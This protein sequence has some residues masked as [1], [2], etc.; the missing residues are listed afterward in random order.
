MTQSRQSF[1]WSAAGLAIFLAWQAFSLRTFIRED[2]RPPAWDQANHMEVAWKYFNAAALGRWGDIWRYTPNSKIPPFPPL[3][4]LG[5]SLSYG[6]ENPAGAALWVNW[7]YLALLAVS[8]FGLAREC[9]RE[10]VAA[11]AAVIVACCPIVQALLRTQLVDLPLTAVTAAAYWALVRCDGFKSRRGSLVFGFAFAAGMMH[12]WSFFSYL[13]PAYYVWFGA[14]RAR[15][16]RANALAAA[17]LGLALSLPWYLIRL[18]LVMIRLT[19][20]SSD[21]VVPF[22]RGAAFFRYF[23]DM[24]SALGLPFW[25]LACF[26]A[27]S[28][29]R[30]QRRPVRLALAW[31][32]SSYL[33]WALVPNRQMRYLLPGLSGLGVLAAAALPK[34]LVWILAAYQIFLAV[35]QGAPAREDWKIAELLRSV[36]ARRPARLPF[37]TLSLVSND[38]CFNKLNF[39]WYADTLGPTGLQVRG[40]NNIPWELSPFVLLKTGS[41]AP[42]SALENLPQAAAIIVRPRGWFS[43]AYGLVERQPLPDGSEALLF[44]QKR[45]AD[46]P[47]RAGARLRLPIYFSASMEI[48]QAVVVLG[49]WDRKRSAYDRVLVSAPRAVV[50]GITI[51][52]LR[53]EVE[54]AVLVPDVDGDKPDGARLLKVGKVTV[55]SASL[56]SRA[57]REALEHVGLSVRG[58]TLERTAQISISAKG[59]SASAEIRMGRGDDSHRCRAD[60][61]A[62]RIG[63]IPLPA[64]AMLRYGANGPLFDLEI[65]R[66]GTTTIRTVFGLSRT[67][68]FVVDVPG[69]SV[70][71]G[72]ITF[73]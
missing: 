2:T 54:D 24:P 56:K 64:R 17:F 27:W 8:V 16:S 73:P 52:D 20:A 71:D 44:Q 69:C 47:F 63:S 66:E 3:Y 1:R 5:L 39:I 61:L 23:L 37:A 7:L 59:L 28:L 41:L 48:P 30:D 12:K 25:A 18:P 53:F 55:R 70:H 51:T 32:L 34:P 49:R 58:L 19:Q 38:A 9:R 35:N 62:A 67:L 21:F 68:P 31:A 46:A 22:W 65:S 43:R 36:G 72:R 42:P 57:I 15:A 6:S 33:F 10:D 60:L 4:H 13:F 11:A 50:R 29:R 14:A 26:A 45:L 40:V